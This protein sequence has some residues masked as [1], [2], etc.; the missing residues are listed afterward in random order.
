MLYIFRH[1]ARRKGLSEAC[2]SRSR[3]EALP[4]RPLTKRLE[5]YVMPSVKAHPNL[6]FSIYSFTVR[7][8]IGP[9]HF[10]DQPTPLLIAAILAIMSSPNTNTAHARQLVEPPPPGESTDELRSWF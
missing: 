9:F 8:S 7:F 5:F 1:Y 10:L 4:D 6:H 2:G 3:E